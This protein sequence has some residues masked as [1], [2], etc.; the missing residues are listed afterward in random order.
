MEL[1]FALPFLMLPLVFPVIA[2][3]L[4]KNS[5][6]SFRFWFWISFLLPFISCII[7]LCL[8]DKSKESVAVENENVLDHLFEEKEIVKTPKLV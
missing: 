6:R 2:G 4:A 8:R 7:L 3:I 1:L 5:G